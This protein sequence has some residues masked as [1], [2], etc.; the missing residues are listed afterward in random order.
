MAERPY[1]F[2]KAIQFTLPWETGKDKNGNLREDGGYTNNP[3]DPGG[4][5]KYGISK[6]ANPDVDIKALTLEQATDIYKT[7]YWD[8]YVTLRPVNAN[9]LNL[10]TAVAVAVFDAGVNCGVNRAIGWLGKAL[11][12][13]SPAKAVNDLRGGYYFNLVST[14]RVKYGSFFKGWNNRL[15]DLRKYCDILETEA[16]NDYDVLQKVTGKADFSS[17]LS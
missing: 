17:S 5:T 9:L 6:R 16:Q 14:D 4:E 2:V 3:A 1:G 11:E 12:A 13:K 7:K 10:P 15:T 8:I